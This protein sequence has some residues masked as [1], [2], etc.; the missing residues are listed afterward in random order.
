MDT[1]IENSQ[2][3]EEL[4]AAIYYELKKHNYRLQGPYINATETEDKLD[5]IDVYYLIGGEK[6]PHQIRAYTEKY[7]L[8]G[9]PVRD[10]ILKNAN[11]AD[12]LKQGVL[13]NVYFVFALAEPV[14]VEKY[15]YRFKK[16]KRVRGEYLRRDIQN[17]IGERVF[18]ESHV[19]YIKDP[20]ETEYLR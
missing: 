18:N 3:S 10:Q 6:V 12:L 14:S 16:I 9:F 8:E 7:F 11:E 17:I 4:K 2:K 20:V 1:F 13:D 19:S 15:K 5:K